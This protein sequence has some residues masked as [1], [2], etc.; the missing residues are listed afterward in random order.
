[1]PVMNP[2]RIAF[3]D[4][5]ASCG[6]GQK[7]LLALMREAEQ[8]GWR[9]SAYLPLG[10]EL[11][12][13]ARRDC[14]G[15]EL[16]HIPEL[17]LNQGR[18]NIVDALQLLAHMARMLAQHGGK[19]RRNDILY[20]NGPR[21]LPHVLTLA[22]FSDCRICC[23][24][25]LDHSG[26]ER[27][28]LRLIAAHA[29][30]SAVVVPSHFIRER[31]CEFS[32]VFADPRVMILET[33]MG[34]EWDLPFEDR[35]EGRPPNSVAVVG[36][37]SREKGQDAL[38]GAAV[39]MPETTFHL[40]GD[41]DFASAS[42]RLELETTMPPN[43]R[44]HGKVRDVPATLRSLGVQFMVIPSRCNEA[45]GLSAV[46]GMAA[47]CL[48][49]VRNRGGL[50][51]I[52][53]N[54]GALTFDSDEDLTRLLLELRQRTGQELAETARAQYASTQARY[55]NAPFRQ[56]VRSLLDGLRR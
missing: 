37:L 44:L 22:K 31:L 52:A 8:S 2:R 53:A 1:M 46:E 15:T 45:F 39:R 50:A 47:S 33:G 36:R 20:V 29:S 28:L 18:K 51:E 23:H 54:T 35:F 40:L 32:P 11:E 19:L 26:P 7:I 30:T 14:P 10:Q 21:L 16:H 38:R 43:V 55:G 49:L 13:L 41:S 48:T 56:R 4:Q 3:L 24:V 42:Y 5:Y 27:H 25:H 34:P 9:T 12:V 17:P 6:G